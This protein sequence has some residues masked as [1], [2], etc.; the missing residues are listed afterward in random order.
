VSPE[1]HASILRYDS[2][3][4]TAPDARRY[5]SLDALRAAMMLLGIVLHSAVN[6]AVVSIGEAWP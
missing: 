6:Y 1:F 3:T 5:H 2:P 4:M